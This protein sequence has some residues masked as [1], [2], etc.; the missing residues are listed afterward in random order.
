MILVQKAIAIDALRLC[1]GRKVVI[2]LVRTWTEELPIIQYLTSPTMMSDSRNRS[3]TL[4]DVILLPD[5]DDYALIIMPMLLRF[6]ILPFRRVG[7]FAE[8]VL[9]FLKVKRLSSICPTD[10]HVALIL[11]S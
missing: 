2:K 6:D 4:L 5:D 1:D 3:V 11:G 8:A 7:E 9:Q 10:S